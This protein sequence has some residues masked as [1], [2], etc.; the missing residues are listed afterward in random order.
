MKLRD[1]F[2]SRSITVGTW[3]T[4]P[5]GGLIGSIL[6]TEIDYVIFDLEHGSFDMG[7][8]QEALR[9]SDASQRA[10]VRPFGLSDEQMSKAI[11]FGAS[12]IQVPGVSSK[13]ETQRVVD[14]CLYSPKGKKGFSPFT[15]SG[16]YGKTPA[17]EQIESTSDELAIIINVESVEAVSN[18]DEVCEV[19]RLDGIFIGKY[20][21]SVSLGEPG[22]FESNSFQ[23]AFS[24]AVKGATRYGKSVATIVNDTQQAHEALEVGVNSLV[25]SV[26]L[27][28]TRRSYSSFIE[29][30]RLS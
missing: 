7:T 6:E 9:V 17:V 13:A 8:L 27:N 22:N 30:L 20:D 14:S 24:H 29:S 2:L 5:S 16:G 4:E 18:I 21:L 1:K 23:D 10:L 25:Y 19:P 26:D 11:D 15:A 12:G 3:I 28:V